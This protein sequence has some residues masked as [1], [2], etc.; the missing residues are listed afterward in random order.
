[1]SNESETEQPIAGGSLIFIAYC[2]ESGGIVRRIRALH[3]VD[4]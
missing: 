3:G 4:D 2:A 1:M